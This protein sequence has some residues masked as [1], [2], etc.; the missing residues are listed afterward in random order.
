[1]TEHE[2]RPA[3]S[4]AVEGGSGALK[5]RPAAFLVGGIP[6]TDEETANRYAEQF[7]YSVEGLYLRSAPPAPG[8]DVEALRVKPLEWELLDT[9]LAD[10]E[11]VT[12]VGVYNV[13]MVHGRAEAILRRVDSTDGWIDVA[14]FS[15]DS[16]EAAKAAAQADYEKRIRSAL[17]SAPRPSPEAEGESEWRPWG[18]EPRGCPTPGACSCPPSQDADLLREAMEAL[19][20]IKTRLSA[21][22]QDNGEPLKS[23]STNEA[24]RIVDETLTRIKA[25]LPEGGSD[26]G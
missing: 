5:K 8:P 4:G 17:A 26:N 18:T 2:D 15:G 1:M 24:W 12:Q 7:N 16:I 20:E 6:I 21:S 10:C 14:I 22:H 23:V 25:R 11:A 13:G 19:D 3:P 9:A